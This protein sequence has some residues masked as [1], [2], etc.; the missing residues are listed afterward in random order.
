H[1]RWYNN[2]FGDNWAA[3]GAVPREGIAAL[4]RTNGLPL[5]WNPRRA[6]GS[7]TRALVA[8]PSG[9]W[10]GS[11][12]TR[13]GG[14]YHAR[15]GFFPAAGGRSLPRIVVGG[16]PGTLYK[17]GPTNTLTRSSFDGTTLGTSSTVTSGSPAWSNARGTYLVSGR[18][19]SGWSD[20]KLYA[21]AFD[22]F[23]LGPAREVNLYGLSN[24]YD[25]S[26]A[27][28]T[29]MFFSPAGSRLYYTRAGHPNLYYRYFTPSSEIVGA[30]TYLAR[31]GGVDWSLVRG[32]TLASGRVYYADGYG[33]LRSIDFSDGGP[34][35][36]TGRL[37]RSGDWRSNGLFVR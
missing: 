15:L 35:A 7:G 22:G 3:P 1:E 17:A 37:V 34:M 31:S 23:T 32:M 27:G 26:L 8:T 36:G 24:P 18:L 14:E 20:G 28:V 33:Y 11:D 19:Y 13:L 29:G 21:R 16:L 10:V 2:P 30:E 5:S 4:D 9:L 12:T 25:F 6:R